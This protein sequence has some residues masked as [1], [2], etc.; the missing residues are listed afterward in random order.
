MLFINI[1]SD[2]INIQNSD[3][4]RVLDGDDVEKQ[5]PAKLRELY[6]EHNYDKIFVLN[7][8][9]SFTTLRVGSLS[10]NMLN[11]IYKDKIDIL[12]VGKIALY[13]SFVQNWLLPDK[14]LIYIGQSSKMRCYNFVKKEHKIIQLEDVDIDGMFV[15]QLFCKEKVESMS[16]MLE[17]SLVWEKIQINY[18]DDSMSIDTNEFGQFQKYISTNYIIEPSIG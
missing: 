8:P 9:G 14:W 1:S 15:D 17:I 13:N 18:N 16:G 6:D 4:S 10:L 3:N 7:W 12:S 11:F 5:L 2:K